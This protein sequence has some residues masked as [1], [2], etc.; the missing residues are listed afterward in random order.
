MSSYKTLDTTRKILVTGAAG[1]IGFHLSRKLLSEGVEVVG[2]D[3]INDYYDVNLKYARLEILKCFQNF[4]FIKG[5]LADKSAIDK[6]FEENKFDIVVNLAAQAGVRYSI[7][8]PQAYMESNIIGFFNILEA[9]R[10]NPVEHLLY[11]S[12]SSVYGNQQ[13]TPFSTD[14]D[15]S[16]PISLY[17][18]TKKSNELMAYTYSHLYGIPSTGLRFFTVYGPFGRPD[19]AYFGFT[20]KIMKGETIKI[21]NNGDMY[22]DFTYIDDIVKGIENMLCNPPEPDEN[23]DMATVYNIGNNSPEKLMY[24]IETLEKA[25][26]KTAVKEFLPMQPGDVYQTYADVT[27]LVEKFGFKPSTSI[28]DGLTKFVQWYKSYYNV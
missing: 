4:T 13:K 10:H 21:F 22:R 24:F 23:G 17:A 25:L 5:D 18:A 8:N 12:S 11:A 1:F 28:E 7:D 15:V 14:D 9:C 19:M 3:N 26:G 2:F 16:K 20:D 6:L 27:P